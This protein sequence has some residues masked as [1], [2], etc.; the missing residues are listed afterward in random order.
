MKKLSLIL[1]A[2]IL[3]GS[4]AACTRETV[5]STDTD[6][7]TESP[8]DT[9][10][11]TTQGENPK[12]PSANKLR[13]SIADLV[14]VPDTPVTHPP[15]D[16]AD[17]GT[18]PSEGLEY[19]ITGNYYTVVGMGTCTDAKLVIPAE[20][21]GKPVKAIG[22]YAFAVYD[23]EKRAY[24]GY[25]TITT[26]V[27]SE[28]IESVGSSAFFRC[29]N[30]RNIQLPDTLKK[31]DG[32]VFN[33]CSSLVELTVPEGITQLGHHFA[34]ECR[35]LQRVTLPST[36]KSIGQDAFSYCGSLYEI[37][38]PVGLTAIGGEA[39]RACFSLKTIHLPATI[40]DINGTSLRSDLD[41]E[42]Q[43]NFGHDSPAGFREQGYSEGDIYPN[44]FIHHLYFDGTL[45]EYLDLVEYRNERSAS[46]GGSFLPYAVNFYIDGE[47]VEYLTLPDGITDLPT[48]AFVGCQSL[49][50]VILP[51]AFCT[52]GVADQEAEW[53]AWKSFLF[54]NCPNLEWVVIE[55]P[56]PADYI[57]EQDAA[58][59]C[60]DVVINWLNRNFY[61]RSEIKNP[62]GDEPY[63]LSTVQNRH[64][65]LTAT[66]EEAKDYMEEYLRASQD[67]YEVSVEAHYAGEWHYDENGHPVPNEK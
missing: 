57:D 42:C 55:S 10:E 50:G 64:F 47:L 6:I 30:M 9:D 5:S 38:L 32:G 56:I 14:Q 20:Y 44:G 43:K 28:G 59:D 4:M 23:E 31:I 11:T 41:V 12:T 21:E 39:F 24:F 25:D 37:N 34:T 1:A 60:D 22:D 27:V 58:N 26:V 13:D 46:L 19:T 2:L 51:D 18:Q 16:P 63:L 62:M 35:S 17:Y 54:M 61:C 67:Y 7:S 29:M 49:K 15:I 65:Y 48:A 3:T 8:S 33:G 53:T 45:E 40:R 36:L 52:A 66:K